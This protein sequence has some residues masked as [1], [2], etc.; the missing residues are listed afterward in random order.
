MSR[1]FCN[2]SHFIF[3]FDSHTLLILLNINF[4]LIFPR[5]FL[6]PPLTLNLDRCL[7]QT[8]IK[9]CDRLSFRCLISITN[10]YF[11][12]STLCFICWLKTSIALSSGINDNFTRRTSLGSLSSHGILTYVVHI[13]V[14]N[15]EDAALPP[16]FLGI[17][18]W[19]I[20]TFF[21]FR[22]FLLFFSDINWMVIDWIQL[23]LSQSYWV[24]FSFN[25]GHI[26]SCKFQNFISIL[27]T[28]PYTSWVKRWIKIGSLICRLLNWKLRYFVKIGVICWNSLELSPFVSSVSWHAHSWL[29]FVGWL[30]TFVFHP[31]KWLIYILFFGVVKVPLGIRTGISSNTRR[32]SNLDW[33]LQ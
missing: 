16:R 25:T 17:Q 32:R 24:K 23:R 19:S 26:S 3:L 22:D 28:C 4:L 10:I 12:R 20:N 8:Y 30:Y 9:Q 11:I 13:D 27:R 1:S 21:N 15:I 18:G 14:G 2:S 5:R 31:A 6:L 7:I 29:G 33:I